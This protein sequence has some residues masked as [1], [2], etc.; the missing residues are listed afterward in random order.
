MSIASKW[1]RLGELKEKSGKVIR[2][3]GFRPFVKKA[4]AWLKA[5]LFRRFGMSPEEALVYPRSVSEMIYRTHENLQPLLVFQSPD[6]G[7]PACLNFVTDALGSSFPDKVGT[8]LILVSQYAVRRNMTLRII[9]RQENANPNDYYEFMKLMHETCPK[10][11][12]FWSDF[13]RNASGRHGHPLEISDSDE[14]F[15]TSWW[16][17]SAVR[18]TGT[19]CKVFYIVQETEVFFYPYGDMRLWCSRQLNCPDIFYIVNS[20]WLWDYFKNRYPST[21]CANGTWFEPAFPRF[22]YY[23]RLSAASGRHKLFFSTAPNRSRSLFFTGLKVLEEAVLR[24]IIDSN[25]WDICIGGDAYDNMV[26]PGGMRPE[27]P[28]RMTWSEYARFL[29]DVDVTFS[30]M[31]T[32]YPGYPFLESLASGCVCVTNSFENKKDCPFSKNAIFRDL[33]IDALCD[34]LREGVKL[35]LDQQER[36]KNFEEMSLPSDWSDTLKGT[37]DFMEQIH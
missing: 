4:C 23:P 37:L 6:R 13:G 19:R 34:G 30:L 29:G 27:Y 21:V 7:R 17:T 3:K 20:H 14:F 28:G 35:A 5:F 32:P 10:K 22:L 2:E 15:T 9:T 24:G 11:V 8:A 26:F 33:N 25:Q 18:A 1:H 12:V 31:S 16:T 36:R